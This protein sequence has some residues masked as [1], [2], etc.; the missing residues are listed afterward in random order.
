[1]LDPIQEAAQTLKEG[2]VIIYPTKT[3]YAL[4]ANVFY[5]PAIQ[6]ISRWKDDSLVGP[7]PIMVNSFH[8][9]ENLA[10]IG[11]GER[12]IL[13]NLWPGPTTVLLPRKADLIT[14][15]IQDGKIALRFSDDIGGKIIE[16]TD[17]ALTALPAFDTNSLPITQPEEIDIPVDFIV[18]G[19]CQYGRLSTIIDLTERKIVRE[20]VELEKVK[21]IIHHY[22]S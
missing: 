13:Q 17:F 9:A 2:G 20:G 12:R 7:I 3:I 4:G 5:L 16:E 18:E 10:Y 14:D 6:K 1:M 22:G 19:L 11:E 8:L 15:F 21:N